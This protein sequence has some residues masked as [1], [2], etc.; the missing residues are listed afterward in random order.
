MTN[1]NC[2]FFG[3]RRRP[4]T[5]SRIGCAISRRFSVERAHSSIDAAALHV[6]AGEIPS[7]PSRR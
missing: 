7:N 1:P 5:R 2:D 4:S 6:P 3:V